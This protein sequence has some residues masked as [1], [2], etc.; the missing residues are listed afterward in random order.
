[1]KY[2]SFDR[3]HI[4]GELSLRQILLVTAVGLAFISGC[5]NNQKGSG[6][7]ASLTGSA[8]T[9]ELKK[10]NLKIASSYPVTVPVLGD[11][12]QY[13][14]D[15]ASKASLGT[16]NFKIFNPGELVN[17]LEI[18]EAVS[19]G[20]VEM[21]YSA[22]GFW[23]GKLPAAPLFATVPFGPDAT[24]YLAWLLA[25]D[26]MDLY[27]EMYDQAGY[28]V[29]VLLCAMIPPETSGW[30]ANRI[31]SPDDLKGLKMRFYGLGGN[32]MAK[33]G[34]AISLTP[35][36]EVYQDLEKGVIDATEYSMPVIDEKLELYKLVKYNYFPGWHQ[37]AT[38]FELLVHKPVW[39]ALHPNQQLILE[40]ACR[41]TIVHSLAFSEAT[42][43][44]V[45]ERNQNER[46]VE[47]SDWSPEM[48]QA[49][50]NAWDEVVQEEK[51]KD[52]FFAR[53]WDNFDAF[54]KKYA[55][56]GTR[57]YLPRK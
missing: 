40:M 48:L 38:T 39:N 11:N 36:P 46:Q 49:F 56:W 35:G 53:V 2:K 15:R 10:H 17:T 8:E 47:I 28:N 45:M 26:G 22:A 14:T 27:Q 34:V 42:Q 12:I 18:L 32:V 29:K 5:G 9:A 7:V 13:L 6:D 37:Q 20:K 24:E 44:D 54:R 21:G 19:G 52:P 51:A 50:K 3:P 16:L 55:I 43:A 4:T 41:D 30:F 57:A 31:D 23:K 25:G 1:M 33:L